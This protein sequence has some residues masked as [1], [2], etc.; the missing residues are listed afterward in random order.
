[1]RAGRGVYP[2]TLSGNAS[3]ETHTEAERL[4]G[5]MTKRNLCPCQRGTRHP[6]LG[7]KGNSSG[8]KP[9]YTVLD[10]HEWEKYIRWVDAIRN[11]NDPSISE[12]VANIAF[13]L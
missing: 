10:G 9:A 8:T 7:N 6:A 12:S 11:A 2:P 13:Q 4:V 3:K 1:M 5:N